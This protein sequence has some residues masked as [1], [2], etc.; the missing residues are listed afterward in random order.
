MISDDEAAE[1]RALI[2]SFRAQHA[3]AM[4]TVHAGW[5]VVA[6]AEA[7]LR[8]H[9]SVMPADSVLADLR[10]LTSAKRQGQR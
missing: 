2:A 5:D 7:I 1:L 4:F 6:D 10:S 3:G 9:P 8:G